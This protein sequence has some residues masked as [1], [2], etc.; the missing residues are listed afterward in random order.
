[1]K[2]VTALILCMAMSLYTHT[3]TATL[4]QNFMSYENLKDMPVRE[5]QDYKAFVS[6]H[7]SIAKPI[8]TTLPSSG[9]QV[10]G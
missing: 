9:L 5:K 2:N 1:M 7:N 4:K 8:Y 3:Y 6:I 10:K